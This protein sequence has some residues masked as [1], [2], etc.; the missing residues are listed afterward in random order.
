MGLYLSLYLKLCCPAH[1]GGLRSSLVFFFICHISKSIARD[2]AEMG[3]CLPGIHGALG[4]FLSYTKAAMVTPAWDPSTGE[5]E[6]SGVQSS[7]ATQ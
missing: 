4:S 3:E 7:L 5:A 6:R 1:P 2:V